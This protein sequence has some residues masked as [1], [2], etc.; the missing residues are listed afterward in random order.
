MNF[1]TLNPP[2]YS[3]NLA[4]KQKSN[5]GSAKVEQKSLKRPISAVNLFRKPTNSGGNPYNP[6]SAQA[7]ASMRQLQMAYDLRPP[8]GVTS[9][10]SMKKDKEG[11]SKKIKKRVKAVPDPFLD[12]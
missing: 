1:Q 10:V 8:S 11:K 5:L 6:M 12:N 9:M 7:L 2:H 4:M 3:S